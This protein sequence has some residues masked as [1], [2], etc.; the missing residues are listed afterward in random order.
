MMD[1]LDKLK[2]AKIVFLGLRAY[3]LLL[4]FIIGFLI[5]AVLLQL[6]GVSMILA[7]APAALYFIVQLFREGRKINIIRHLETSYGGLRERLSTAYDNR[8]GSNLIV[9]DLMNDV[10]VRLEDVETSSFVESKALTSRTVATVVLTFI[11][12]T[13]TVLNIRGLILGVINENTDLSNAVNNAKERYGNEFQAMM[14]Q[15][16]EGSNWSAENEEEKLG[17]QPGGSRPGYGQGPIPGTGFGVGSESSADIYGKASAA[18]I[19]GKNI[20]FQL[21]PEYGGNIEIRESDGRV[22]ANDFAIT[23]VESADTCTDCAVGP[24]HEEIV[25]RYFEKISEGV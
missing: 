24:E 6:L 9:E 21:H 18:S 23:N 8:A 12:L 11:L 19:E 10:S 16:W 22:S 13:V 1:V 17:A 7:V 15:R 2:E 5:V 3:K 4:D 25:R 14:G 20:D